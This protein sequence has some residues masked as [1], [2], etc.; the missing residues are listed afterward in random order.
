MTY[1]LLNLISLS[2]HKVTANISF[3]KKLITGDIN[4]LSEVNFSFLS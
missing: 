1:K 2:D 3:F 4:Y